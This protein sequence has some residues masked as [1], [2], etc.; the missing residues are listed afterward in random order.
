[1]HVQGFVALVVDELLL[2]VTTRAA[3][4]SSR[5]VLALIV[6][7]SNYEHQWDEECETHLG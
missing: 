5:A 7:L 4:V 3:S 6:S 2:D 1:M